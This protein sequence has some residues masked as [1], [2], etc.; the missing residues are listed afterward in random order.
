MPGARDFPHPLEV[1]SLP[2]ERD[3]RCGGS[4][5]RASDLGLEA[6]FSKVPERFWA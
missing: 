6:H 3:G 4:V 2:S 5:V 1:L